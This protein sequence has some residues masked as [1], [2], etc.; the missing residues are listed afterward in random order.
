[1]DLFKLPL[2]ISGKI[3]KVIHLSDIHIRSGDKEISRYTEY[4]E[5]FTNL[6]KSLSKEISLWYSLKMVFAL[7]GIFKDT[8]LLFL[9]IR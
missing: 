8:N 6:I 7:S 1:M 2:P 5:V 9:F 4:L 3:L